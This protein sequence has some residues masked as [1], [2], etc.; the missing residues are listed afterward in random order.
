MTAT[1][2]SALFSGRSDGLM[3]SALASGSSSPGSIVLCSWV[4]RLILTVPLYTQVFIGVPAK[5]ML[6]ETLQWTSILSRKSKSIPSP[7][8]KL[9]PGGPFD[10]YAD[11][12]F[13][14]IWQEPKEEGEDENEEEEEKN[15]KVNQEFL[16][17]AFDCLGQSWPK[18]STDSQ[19]E[20][21]QLIPNTSRM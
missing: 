7:W 19:G 8:D 18:N 12:I 16:V 15:K 13:V 11:L 4:R 6:G 21:L 17:C 5:V 9:L 20:L 10:S 14:L 2:P 3:V 1:R